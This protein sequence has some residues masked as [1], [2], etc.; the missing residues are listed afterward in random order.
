MLLIMEG[1]AGFSGF[2]LAFIIIPS[3]DTSGRTVFDSP[4]QPYNQGKRFPK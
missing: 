3:W 4:I 2:A 1:K